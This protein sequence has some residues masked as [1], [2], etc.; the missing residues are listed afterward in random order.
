MV[1]VM[2]NANPA[3]GPLGYFPECPIVLPTIPAWRFTADAAAAAAA[4]A[5]AEY[6]TA[7]A[8]ALDQSCRV[9]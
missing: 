5:A 4:A 2:R 8:E 9:R 7:V 1:D 6:P 3:S